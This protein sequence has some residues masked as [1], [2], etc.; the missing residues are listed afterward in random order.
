MTNDQT[1]I[2]VSKP[3]HEELAVYKYR[4]NYKSFEEMLESEIVKE[5]E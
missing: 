3:L 4:H 5:G 1:T 2:G